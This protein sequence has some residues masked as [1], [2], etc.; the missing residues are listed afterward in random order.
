[1]PATKDVLSRIVHQRK[2]I[3]NGLKK[4]PP[5]IPVRPAK[6]PRIAPKNMRAFLLGILW[7]VGTLPFDNNFQAE[8][9]RISAS[10]LLCNDE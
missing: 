9:I 8:K 5:P 10:M 1:M 4:I 6:K 2:R 3:S 7:V